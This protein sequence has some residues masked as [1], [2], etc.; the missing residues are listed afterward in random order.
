MKHFNGNMSKHSQQ[1]HH[2][3]S[4]NNHNH[5]QNIQQTPWRA[6]NRDNQYQ[7]YQQYQQHADQKL[8][9]NMHGVGIPPGNQQQRQQQ[10]QYQNENENYIF[11]QPPLQLTTHSNMNDSGYYNNRQIR[12]EATMPHDP[13]VTLPLP[14]S[15]IKYIEQTIE[16]LINP[17]EYHKYN[18]DTI[19]PTLP[20][21][22]L[23]ILSNYHHFQQVGEGAY[24][25]VYK[26]TNRIDNNIY[27]LKRL[28][29]SK[30]TNGV[31]GCG[32]VFYIVYWYCY[33]CFV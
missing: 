21:Y 14:A 2:V 1:T 23:G 5:N 22:G 20:R 16:T 3:N 17:S 29:F 12:R 28:V 32:V 6:Q 24:G 11:N 26:A 30:D 15:N 27:A 13:S 4:N 18:V 9:R 7:E 31:S 33:A 8:P 19:A 25:Y 10:Y